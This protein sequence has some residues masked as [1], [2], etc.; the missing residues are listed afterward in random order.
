YQDDPVT[1]DDAG[2]VNHFLP[3]VPAQYTLPNHCVPTSDFLGLVYSG[4]VEYTAAVEIVPGPPVAPAILT[5]G[6]QAVAQRYVLRCE[7]RRLGNV[8]E[9]ARIPAPP[10]P[11]TATHPFEVPLEPGSGA[12]PFTAVSAFSV[13]AREG[14]LTESSVEEF[15]Q[16][17]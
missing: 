7:S 10:V 9:C 16:T 5:A 14:G 15:Y 1:D 2:T 3:P 6:A 13:D 8:G 12:L 4:C 17:V 11:V